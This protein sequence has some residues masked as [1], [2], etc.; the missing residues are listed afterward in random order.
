MILG[1]D[2]S[3]IRLG[4]GVY[5]LV[6]LLKAA[7]PVSHGFDRVIVWGCSYTLDK[8]ENRDWLEKVYISSLDKGFVHRL[9]WQ[10]FRLKKLICQSNCDLLFSPGGSDATHFKPLVTMNQNMLPFEW[11]E[12]A[13]FGFSLMTLKFIILRFT[14][15]R[16][17]KQAN[18]I[19]F[20][21]QY[22]CDG[23]QKVTDRLSGKTIVIPHGINDRFFIQPRPQRPKSEFTISQPC[24]L[25]YI[26]TI[27]VYKHQ[28]HVCQ[29]VANLRQEGIPLV[30]DLVG[31]AGPAISKLKSKLAQV[32]PQ[33]EYI[34]YHG[35]IKY[36]ELHQMYLS[37]DIG[38][39]ASSCETISLILLENMAAGLPIACSLKGSM[40]EM[41]ENA[42]LYFD[43]EKPDEIAERL[44]QLINSD[45]LR[46]DLAKAAFQKAKFYSWDRCARETFSFIA[47]IAKNSST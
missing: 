28:W 3:N 29:A 4:G 38:V 22:A 43:P 40:S 7:D 41:L 19:I 16:T 10:T 44:R 2:A 21:T 46:S 39:F 6:E 11:R 37:A 25:L 33:Q 30:L 32:D 17:F 31:P 26:S 36:E 23:V 35:T 13:R 42:G 14:Q 47:D 45:E 27:D 24:R 18:G 1:I 15:S 9:F 8:I 34:K 12:L 20:L 5:H